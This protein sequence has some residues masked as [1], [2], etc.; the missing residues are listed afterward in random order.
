MIIPESPRWLTTKGRHEEALKALKRLRGSDCTEEDL[1][2]EMNE[3]RET[4]RIEQELGHNVSFFDLFRGT[5][6]RRTILAILCSSTQA[7]SGI[8]L[9]VGYSTYF[10]TVAGI[11][12]PFAITLVGQAIGIITTAVALKLMNI[13]RRRPMF[14]TGE[15]SAGVCLI[16]I[17]GLTTGTQTTATG[18]AMVAFSILYTQVSYLVISLTFSVMLSSLVLYPG[19]A[20]RKFLPTVCARIQCRLPWLS[21]GHSRL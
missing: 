18:K 5:D 6:L 16:I 7:G 21:V 8:N 3:I 10:Y 1:L 17:A 14:I 9:V 4:T 13:Y 2:I 15:I 12:N 19:L 20:P 11:S